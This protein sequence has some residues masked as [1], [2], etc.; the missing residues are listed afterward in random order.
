[1]THYTSTTRIALLYYRRTVS[2]LPDVNV[3]GKESPLVLKPAPAKVACENRQIAGSSIRKR[4]PLSAGAP[5]I[6]VSEA[7]VKGA[8][9]EKGGYTSSRRRCS[10]GGACGI[11]GRKKDAQHKNEGRYCED[12]DLEIDNNGAER[13]LRGIAVGRRMGSSWAATRGDGPRPCSPVSSPPRRGWVS[14]ASLTCATSSTASARIPRTDSPN[15][16]PTSVGRGIPPPW[17]PDHC[18]HCQPCAA[19]AI[20]TQGR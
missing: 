14:I 3:R 4:H 17:P 13:S 9:G 11:A 15:C 16:S 5:H 12:S 10:D 7:E 19:T 18:L 20:R 1:M 6:D 2:G 8:G